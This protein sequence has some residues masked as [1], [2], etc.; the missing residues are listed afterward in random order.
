MYDVE[1]IANW[2]LSK[3]SMT[4]KKLQKL[5]YYAQAWYAT[6]HEGEKL[7]DGEFEAWIH[8]PVN[9]KLY[10]IFSIYGWN[11]IPVCEEKPE[12]E[13]NIEEF[14]E[15]IYSSFGKFDGDYLEAMTHSELPWKEARGCCEPDEACCEVIPLESMVKYY[16]QLSKAGQVE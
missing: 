1:K 5:C 6:L 11:P 15:V 10:N 9:R 7:I 12:F 16:T 13:K 3:E 8:G 2:F 14:L 4:H